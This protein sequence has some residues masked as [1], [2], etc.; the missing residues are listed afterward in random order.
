MVSL[1]GRKS[2]RQGASVSKLLDQAVARVRT[3]PEE[4]QNELGEL[5]LSLAEA[6]GNEP[7][8]SP[9]Q[10]AEVRRRLASAEPPL[11]EAE[12]DAFF[13]RLP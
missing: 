7:R 5:L 10:A 4:R 1:P 9:V 8:L 11:S 6:E 13:A 2:L 3:L 12:A